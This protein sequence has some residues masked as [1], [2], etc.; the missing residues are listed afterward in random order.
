MVMTWFSFAFNAVVSDGRW[1]DNFD[2]GLN[3][4]IRLLTASAA[5][6]KAFCTLNLISVP[7]CRKTVFG[8]L[9]GY[10]GTFVYLN[11]WIL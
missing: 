4:L 9:V 10:W 11:E 8:K 1:G 2:F 7:D 3:V 6:S 5:S